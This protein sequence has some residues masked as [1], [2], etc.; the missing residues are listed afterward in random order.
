MVSRIELAYR[1]SLER[2]QRTAQA[3]F[4]TTRELQDG[5]KPRQLFIRMQWHSDNSTQKTMLS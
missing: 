3:V 2:R 4:S 1:H 5:A